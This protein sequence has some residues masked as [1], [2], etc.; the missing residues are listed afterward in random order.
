MHAVEHR[1]TGI[2]PTVKVDRSAPLD[3]GSRFGAFTCMP[4]ILP[5]CALFWGVVG[6]FIF[7]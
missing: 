5:I 7:H 2:F 6:Y 1:V 3:D 4:Y